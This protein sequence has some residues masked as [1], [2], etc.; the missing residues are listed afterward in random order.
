MSIPAPLAF[1]ILDELASKANSRRIVTSR[2]TGKLVSIKSKKALAWWHSATQ[3]LIAQS[4]MSTY[5]DVALF[6]EPVCVT[7]RA[8]YASERPDLD[9]SVLLDVL[10]SR[11][12]GKGK[13][14][15]LCVAGVIEND[16]LVR[17]FHCYHRIDAD[18]PRAEVVVEALPCD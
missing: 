4:L 18:N 11:Y 6:T 15:R 2:L 16:R 10:Q 8:F 5:R 9:P 13:K 17:E 7:V 14:R 3:Q 12:D 1:T